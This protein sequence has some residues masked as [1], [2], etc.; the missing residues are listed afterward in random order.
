MIYP[1]IM[2][3]SDAAGREDAIAEEEVIEWFKN[4]TYGLKE[5]AIKIFLAAAERLQL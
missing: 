1:N 3:T 4:H 5:G 2:V